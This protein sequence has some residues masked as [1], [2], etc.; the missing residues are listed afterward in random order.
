[1]IYHIYHIYIYIYSP[2]HISDEQVTDNFYTE[3]TSLTRNIPKHNILIIGGDLNAYLGKHD[4]YKYS[5][6]R[7]TKSKW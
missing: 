3:L 1:M 7:T 2:T 6:H 4:G 5:L